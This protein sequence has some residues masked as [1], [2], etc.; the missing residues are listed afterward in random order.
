METQ[1]NNLPNNPELGDEID[2]L[3]L[4]KTLWSGRKTVLYCLLVGTLL[5]LLVA[6]FSPKEYTATTV[7][8]PQMGSSG[9]SQL[10]GL[11]ALAGI[12]LSSMTNKSA[13]L[14]PVV[15]PQIVQSIPFKLELMKAPLHFS[16]MDQ[17]VSL[18][19][20]YTKYSKPSTLGVVKK[21]TLGLPMVLLGAVS[22]AIKGTPKELV[23][24]RDSTNR[25]IAL[26]T[27]QNKV[28]KTLD[29]MVSLE[30]NAKE[31][32]L[33]LTVRMPEALAAAELAQIAQTLLQR[34]IIAFKIEK[35]QAELEFIQGRYDV[36]KAEFEKVQVSLAVNT[37][38]NKNFTSGLSQIET[39]RVQTRYNIAYS[40]FQE[41][42]KQLEQAKI[43]V[44]K[45]TPVFT[46]IE[47]VSIPSQKSKPNRPMILMIWIFLGGVVGVGIVFGRGYL[48]E[49]M[50]KWKEGGAG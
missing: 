8:V 13:E 45:D 4:A 39:S 24:P 31:G 36:A 40:I 3:A 49:V 17:P 47:P 43:Q 12:D 26:S 32:Y 33:T 5:G 27:E 22:K 34:D 15:Y 9:T 6:L 30:V 38:R 35:T 29:Q 16:G 25:P 42:A 46:I 2:L 14:S 48:K 7:L 20:Y 18:F 10:G 37:D 1:Q 21:Y 19:E 23:L 50:N 44:K 11:A 41:L 28:K